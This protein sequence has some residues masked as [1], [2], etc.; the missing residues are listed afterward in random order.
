MVS[1]ALYQIFGNLFI[2]YLGVIIIISF[3]VTAMSGFGFYRGL[4]RFKW[5]TIMVEHTI[6]LAYY[7]GDYF[8]SFLQLFL[9]Y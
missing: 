8:I 6:Y 9:G 4:L 3:I 1:I 2:I 7:N 5:H